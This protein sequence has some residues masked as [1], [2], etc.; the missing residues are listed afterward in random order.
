M[1][2]HL[3]KGLSPGAEGSWAPSRQLCLSFT[4]EGL[5]VYMTNSPTLC[6]AREG[7]T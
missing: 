2:W 7:R 3:K 1:L 6:A 5:R 4:D